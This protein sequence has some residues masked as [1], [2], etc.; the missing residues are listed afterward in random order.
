[1]MKPSSNTGLP[2]KARR[3]TSGDSGS[4]WMRSRRKRA[5]VQ[6]HFLEQAAVPDSSKPPMAAPAINPPARAESTSGTGL[7]EAIPP[8]AS[9]PAVARTMAAFFTT[10]SPLLRQTNDIFKGTFGSL[11]KS[12]SRSGPQN[13]SD[14][15]GLGAVRQKL[16][17]TVNGEWQVEA[18]FPPLC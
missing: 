16:A 7:G 14:V 11:P 6:F 4:S 12:L 15:G 8:R 18:G 9:A 3:A 10:K 5:T 1:M 17:I 13:L 2:R